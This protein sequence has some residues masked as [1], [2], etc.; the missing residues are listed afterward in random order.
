MQNSQE[1]SQEDDDDVIDTDKTGFDALR[2]KFIKSYNG[3]V[4]FSFALQIF[5]IP[6]N[7]L[8]VVMEYMP[9]IAAKH[10]PKWKWQKEDEK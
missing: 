9:S 5:K 1:N 8:Q 2:G 10:K 3:N 6:I 7:Y 4:L